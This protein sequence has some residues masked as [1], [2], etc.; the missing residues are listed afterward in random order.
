MFKPVRYLEPEA[1]EAASA[2]LLRR[3][4]A[5]FGRSA[6]PVPI[7]AIA[8]QTLDLTISWEPIGNDD[9]LVLG[10][11]RV[12]DRTI[13]L[14]DLARGYFG[15]FPGSEAFTL[16]HEIAHWALHVDDGLIGQVGLGLVDADRP[17]LCVHLD[18]RRLP[19]REWQA[20][21]YAASLLLPRELVARALSAAE[22]FRRWPSLFRLAEHMGV[23][24]TAL[25]IRLDELGLLY[26]GP[27]K[28]LYPS[29]LD[30]AGQAR[31]R[32]AADA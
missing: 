29:R 1:I 18:G 11:L 28:Q 6:F 15:E 22:R 20:N 7:E 25:T 23:S 21:A 16:A 4:T 19:P 32:L 30:A 17:P 12:I 9:P 27:D 14:N 10:A 13:V 5:H 8:E 26:V 31:L 2:E 3:H 24:I